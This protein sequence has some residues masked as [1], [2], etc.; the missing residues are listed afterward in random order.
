MISCYTVFIEKEQSEGRVDCVVETPRFVYIFEFKRDGNSADA[1]QQ[2][3]DKG[4]EREYITDGRKIYK[5][6]CS[7]SSETGTIDDWDVK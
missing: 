2:I 1:L 3:K 5:I 7:F 6:G 4:Y